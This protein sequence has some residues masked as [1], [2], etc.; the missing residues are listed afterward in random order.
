MESIRLLAHPKSARTGGQVHFLSAKTCLLIG[1]YRNGKEEHCRYFVNRSNYTIYVYSSLILTKYT[2]RQIISSLQVNRN[3]LP[4][5]SPS[6]CESQHRTAGQTVGG[7]LTKDTAE[8]IACRFLLQPA[9]FNL[10][11][12]S[13]FTTAMASKYNL[14]LKKYNC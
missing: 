12:G 8:R 2:C 14:G 4:S 1:G 6:S 10:T 11:N 9:P 13:A 3:G 5:R 7:T